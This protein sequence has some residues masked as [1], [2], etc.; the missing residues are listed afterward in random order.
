MRILSYGWPTSWHY[1]PELDTLEMATPNII[2]S[3][4]NHATPAQKQMWRDRGKIVLHQIVKLRDLVAADGVLLSS[5]IE[6][7]EGQPVDGLSLDE[8]C[9]GQYDKI[10]LGR[11]KSALLAYREQFPH[12]LLHGWLG[13]CLHDFTDV[14]TLRLVYDLC[15]WVSPEIY[16][17]ENDS[18]TVQVFLRRYRKQVDLSRTLIG[19]AV[20]KDYRTT[21]DGW[22]PHLAAQIRRVVA[23]GC[24]GI[25]M[26]A[27]VHLRD[28]GERRAL[29]ELLK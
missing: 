2:A 7:T 13:Y 9:L 20:H 29:D 5:M 17:H 3:H 15:D 6:H 8:F 22:L 11:I 28:E 1:P 4:I 16:L 24:A 10:Q 25:A 12:M 14:K 23:L 26:W 27:P 18:M 19:I 21:E